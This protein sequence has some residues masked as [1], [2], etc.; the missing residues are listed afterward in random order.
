MTES[1]DQ[2]FS[3]PVDLGRDQI[4]IQ[5]SRV[6]I[7]ILA[8]FVITI[9]GVVIP[10]RVL[11]PAW[12]L[13]VIA[14]LVGNG[15]I[16]LVG[17]LLLPIA[18]VIDPANRRLQALW[19]KLRTW[20]LLPVIGYAL[21]IPLQGVAISRG[22]QNAALQQNRQLSAA[23]ARITELRSALQQSKTTAELGDRLKQMKAPLL[24]P[25][26]LNQPLPVLRREMES[27]LR[28][29]E[30]QLRQNAP[31][32]PLASIWALVQNGIREM[33]TS[34]LYALA[35]A[36][37]A[38]RPATPLSL[39]EEWR[40]AWSNGRRRAKARAK[41]RQEAAQEQ[42]KNRKGKPR[43]KGLTLPGL[44]RRD[45]DRDYFRRISKDDDN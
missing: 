21:C 9:V 22:L 28:I 3:R 5:V 34:L 29:A 15:T 41:E 20:A 33:L 18:V 16:P 31:R 14:A 8:V 12:Q 13:R 10:P 45:A 27:S 32:L 38:Y 17:F 26:A 44:G 1:S 4:A 42:P 7:L 11:D 30:T 2:A 35:F 39:L 24:S 43:R 19:H 37:V 40:A 6:G 25:A 36:C 23:N